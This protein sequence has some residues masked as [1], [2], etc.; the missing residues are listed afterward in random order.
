MMVA[1]MMDMGL[2]KFLDGA[3]TGFSGSMAVVAA[4]VLVMNF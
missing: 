2:G 1:N 4:A 3:L